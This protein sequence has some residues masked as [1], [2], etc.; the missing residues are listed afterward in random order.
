[1]SKLQQPKMVRAA[2][3]IDQDALQSVR[4]RYRAGSFTRYVTRPLSLAL[5]V[6]TLMLG[7]INLIGEVMLDESWFSIA[8]FLF[9]VVLEAIY[10]TNW[11][12]HPDRL[13]LNRSAYRAAEFFI[14]L[15]ILRL[16]ILFIFEGGLPN[17][18]QFEL[19][20]RDP[21]DFFL[22]IPF[23][24][25]S[26]LALVG[27]RYAVILSKIFSDLEV[28]EFEL[29]FYSLTKAQRKAEAEDQPIQPSRTRMVESYARFWIWGGILLAATI[30]LS[31][32]NIQSIDFLGN[33]LAMGGLGLETSHLVILIV[34]FGLGFW[35]LS[36]AKLMEMNAR[37]L[38]NDLGK[39]DELTNKWQRIT[40]LAL[41]FVGLVAAFL[42]TGP[43]LT[44]GH[45]VEILIST[46][47]FLAN[48]LILL[49]TLPFALI[50][51]LFSNRPLESFEQPP[52]LIPEGFVENPPS[53]LAPFNDTITMILSSAFWSIF[54][55]IFVLAF[56]FFLRE[57][58]QGVEGINKKTIWQRLKV[59]LV[60][61]WFRLR[62]KA[63]TIR[64]RIPARLVIEKDDKVSAKESKKRWRFIRVGGLP[65]REQ[66][67]YF[68]LS[69]VRR[70]GERGVQ[71]DSAETPLEFSQDL[72]S[73]WPEIEEEV[74]ELTDAFLRARYSEET[75]TKA[76]V[77][78]VK[79]TWKDVRREI[80]N[81]PSTA[82][83]NVDEESAEK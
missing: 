82:D 2:G 50:L 40:L 34:Y 70:A 20:L 16:V 19:Y 9:I 38:L 11:L 45:I 26:F 25:G 65:P 77:P 8:Y 56:L 83:K 23:V 48:L 39:D 17:S 28:S 67:R 61:F 5:L 51:S 24:I 32:L 7:L 72:K 41:L 14:I 30:G 71:R 1:M 62:R 81:H 15:I 55:V 22:N 12:R 60:D 18:E 59:W 37:W 29:R 42:P 43:T 52:P 27:W 13:P 63:E 47:L 73:G 3:P 10:T 4:K 54:V 68:Y 33:P 44:I 21:L 80:R 57:R 78:S 74:G 69:T 75:I 79:K 31:T 66:I 6:S 76:D 46:L 36:Q 53:A 58:R 64:L 35:L 49:I